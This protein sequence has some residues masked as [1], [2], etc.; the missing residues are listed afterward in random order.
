MDK[1]KSCS[2]RA[3]KFAVKVV[4]FFLFLSPIFHWF[5][6]VWGEWYTLLPVRQSTQQGCRFALD[7]FN[8]QMMSESLLP[9][10]CDEY[11]RASGRMRFIER[12]V[13]PRFYEFM[14]LYVA[15]WSLFLFLYLS[16]PELYEYLYVK[17]YIIDE[18]ESDDERE[19]SCQKVEYDEKGPFTR[20]RV[21]GQKF[22]LRLSQKQMGALSA[23]IAQALMS[24][25]TR[26]EKEAAVC[27]NVPKPGTLPGHVDFMTDDNVFI[28]SGFRVEN[29][30][31]TNCHVRKH[32]RELACPIFMVVD[33]LKAPFDFDVEP[34]VFCKQT[35]Q[36]GYEVRPSIFANL[37]VKSLRFALGKSSNPF[38]ITGRDPLGF[39]VVSRGLATPT[40]K[41]F[42]EYKHTATTFPGFSGSALQNDRREVFA[43]HVGSFP[44]RNAN[45]AFGT[46]LL[47][48]HRDETEPPKNTAF[49]LRQYEDLDPRVND[50]LETE[51]RFNRTGSYE[52]DLAV[53]AVEVYRKG[54]FTEYK[55]VGNSYAPMTPNQVDQFLNPKFKHKS[56]NDIDA[57]DD[58]DDDELFES[59]LQGLV[60]KRR[61]AQVNLASA[62]K[63]RGVN[64]SNRDFRAGPLRVALRRAKPSIILS[65]PV[66]AS[67]APSP[68]VSNTSVDVTPS[69]SAPSPQKTKPSRS[70]GRKKK[71][72]VSV[73]SPTPP[74][75]VAPN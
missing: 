16:L 26:Q 4:S 8:K 14:A 29:I 12:E 61:S 10:Y 3:L 7:A 32:A 40:G 21:A 71:S 64:E 22:K 23:Q 60:S 35:D 74:V 20:L 66:S 63:V 57:S 42:L 34:H 54:F 2:Y 65:P 70:R 11:D 67:P 51:R 18:V 50:E 37:G 6:V 59:T 13:E 45:R 1:I 9:E 39:P 72:P 25:D 28:G 62:T 15:Y 44:E 36:V 17:Y 75:E 68:I 58:E 73:G 27:G 41:A 5:G 52:D 69:G 38:S 24:E 43:M 46:D 49:L 48:E 19:L 30:L 47:V 31:Y 33:S 55:V 56:W 53:G